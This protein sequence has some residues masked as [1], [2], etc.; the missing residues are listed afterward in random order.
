MSGTIELRRIATF[1]ALVMAAVLVLTTLMVPDADARKRKPSYNTVSCPTYT[2]SSD[3]VCRGTNGRDLLIGTDEGN[4]IR[5]QEGNDLYASGGSGGEDDPIANPD[6]LTDTSTTSNDYYYFGNVRDI[7]VVT[8]DDGG[9]TDTLGLTRHSINDVR[10]VFVANL[11]G[12][13]YLELFIVFSQDEF[14]T[15]YDFVDSAGE[16]GP[17]FIETT[18]FSDGTLSG[19]ELIEMVENMPG[20][21]ASNT[22]DEGVALDQESLESLQEAAQEEEESSSSQG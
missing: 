13:R 19:Q 9:G 20:Q 17:G 5:G 8:I 16:P 2:D 7:G 4:R 22:A 6:L 10:R 11:D 12:D 21:E 18:S 14:V 3:T 1:F 15:I